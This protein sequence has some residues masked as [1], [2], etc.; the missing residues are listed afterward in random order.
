MSSI[1]AFHHANCS[2][3][4]HFF[5]IT[6]QNNDFGGW[7]GGVNK[8]ERMDGIS[9]AAHAI[10]SSRLRLLTL[11]GSHFVCALQAQGDL[12]TSDNSILIPLKVNILILFPEESL[13]LADTQWPGAAIIASPTL[14]SRG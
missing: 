8:D 13:S 4:F 2:L 11:Y 12:S 1:G 6:E 14:S 5:S 10:I 9:T 7:S 3:P